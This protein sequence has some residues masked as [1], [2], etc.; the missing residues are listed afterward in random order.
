MDQ[1]QIKKR[2]KAIAAA[3][4]PLKD[5]VVKCDGWKLLDTEDI[6]TLREISAMA[7]T[8]ASEPTFRTTMVADLRRPYKEE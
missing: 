7:D 8:I 3:L 4:D 2:I 1:T 6:I 5:D